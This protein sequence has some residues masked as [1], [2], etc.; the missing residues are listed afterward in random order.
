MLVH[1]GEPV[2]NKVV[3][4]TRQVRFPF[5]VQVG[6]STPLGVFS[7]PSSRGIK[8]AN[9]DYADLL[10]RSFFFWK[11]VVYGDTHGNVYRWLRLKGVGLIRRKN[12][13]QYPME[14]PHSIPRGKRRYQDNLGIVEGTNAA[15]TRKV[16]EK[17]LRAGIRITPEIAHIKLFQ[18]PVEKAGETRSYE[19]FLKYL[20]PHVVLTAFGCLGKVADAP[21]RALLE[22]AVRTVKSELGRKRFSKGDYLHWFACTFAENLAK[23]HSRGWLHN[24]ITSHNVTLDARITDFDTV[25]GIGCRHKSRRAFEARRGKEAVDAKE[26]LASLVLSFDQNFDQEKILDTFEEVYHEAYKPPKKI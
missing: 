18:Y 19:L 22:K 24:N 14:L 8:L 2:K 12:V 15:Y 1:Y 17:F 20:D 3:W 10:S 5:R 26:M 25:S 13:A 23:T 9:F 6:K 16:S 7:I 11:P 21:N 4:A